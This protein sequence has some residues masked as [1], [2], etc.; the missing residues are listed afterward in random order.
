[1]NELLLCLRHNK[2]NVLQ[3][4]SVSVW[5]GSRRMIIRSL[6]SYQIDRCTFYKKIPRG[7]YG[8][9]FCRSI[10]QSFCAEHVFVQIKILWD[11]SSAKN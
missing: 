9:I 3:K 7:V 2:F 1:M 8:N 10:F 4:N 6:P 11:E 5:Q